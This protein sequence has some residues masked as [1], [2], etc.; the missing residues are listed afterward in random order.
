MQASSSCTSLLSPPSS[1]MAVKHGPCFLTEKKRIQAFETECLRKLLCIS[2]LEHKTNNW[3][4]SKINFLLGPRNLF[5]PLSR[6][7]NLHGLGMLHATRSLLKPS[8]KAPWREGDAEVGTGNAGWT[9][10]KSGH[11]CPCQNCS[12]GPPAGQKKT[13][14]RSLLNRPT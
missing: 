8:F 3:L 7:R 2:Y 6:D 9:T 4:R 12:R 10:S 13:E 11:P 14:R 1:S 5:W